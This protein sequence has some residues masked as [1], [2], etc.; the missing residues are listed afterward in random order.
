MKKM[1]NCG[2][3]SFREKISRTSRTR[4]FFTLLGISTDFLKKNPLTWSRDKGYLLGLEKVKNFR[5]TNDV[6]ERFVNLSENLNGTLTATEEGY[7]NLIL[8]VDFNRKVFPTCNK[9]K[10]VETLEKFK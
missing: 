6:A 2:F 8:N 4:K 5:V 1:K 3:L 7:Q 10:M 9:G